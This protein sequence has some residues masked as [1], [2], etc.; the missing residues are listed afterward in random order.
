MAGEHVCAHHHAPRSCL[1]MCRHGA[2]DREPPPSQAVGKPPCSRWAVLGFEQTPKVFLTPLIQQKK[3]VQVSWGSRSTTAILPHT[4][5][6][7]CHKNTVRKLRNRSAVLCGKGLFLSTQRLQKVVFSCPCSRGASPGLSPPHWLQVPHVKRAGEGSKEGSEM[8]ICITSKA[9]R[10]GWRGGIIL[11][12]SQL[13]L[14]WEIRSKGKRGF[15]CASYASVKFAKD[16]LLGLDQV[17]HPCRQSPYCMMR[18]DYL[19]AKG[20]PLQSTM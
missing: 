19:L 10:E 2:D 18:L 6:H 13:L 8:R 16:F 17:V 11:A 20:I 9:G 5:S 14:P 12:T 3:K 15:L 7:G 4:S 1:D